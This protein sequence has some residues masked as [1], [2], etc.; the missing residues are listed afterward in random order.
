[1]TSVT[2][3]PIAS[4]RVPDRDESFLQKHA[5]FDE[6]LR[7]ARWSHSDVQTAAEPGVLPGD[8]ER[9]SSLRPWTVEKLLERVEHGQD[10][11]LQTVAQS[12]PTRGRR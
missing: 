6:P 5:D 9:D 4:S 2:W 8:W 3:R 7:V 10:G 11:G 12:I 1:M